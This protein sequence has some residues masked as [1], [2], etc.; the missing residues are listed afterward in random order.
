M[1]V[2]CFL[3]I[4]VCLTLG[5]CTGVADLSPTHGPWL[6]VSSPPTGAGGNIPA[7]PSDANCSPS[8]SAQG[9]STTP[10]SAPAIQV[11][12]QS[13]PIVTEESAPNPVLGPAPK[14][15]SSEV[16]AKALEIA[17]KKLGDNNLPPLNLKNLT[18]QSAEENI[19]AIVK[20]LNTVQEDDKRK[21]WT[22]TWRGKEVIFV[23]HLGKI[24]KRVEK[25]TKVVDTAIQRNPQVSALVWAGIWAI[26]RVRI[27]V[28]SL[29]V[30]ALN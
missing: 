3:T 28:L 13:E 6:Y 1:Y 21:R 12:H 7:V 23:E 5:L 17:K 8:S 14:D 10:V 29:V 19:E 26:M 2:H 11:S 30:G 27:D 9:S 4:A 15:P 25:Y 22:Y 16:W 20:A 24:L 18:S